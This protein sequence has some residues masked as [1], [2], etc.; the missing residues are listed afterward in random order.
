MIK[1]VN[2]VQQVGGFFPGIPV[3]P[4][5]KTD[6]EDITSILLKVA[7]NTKPKPVLCIISIFSTG[8]SIFRGST[9]LI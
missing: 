5:N 2:D 9:W 7:L 1:L 3:S 6:H 8:L 4:T